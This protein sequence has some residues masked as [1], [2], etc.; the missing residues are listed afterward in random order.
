MGSK[1][2]FAIRA[3]IPHENGGFVV[4]TFLITGPESPDEIELIDFYLAL[5]DS[6]ISVFEGVGDGP[7]DTGQDSMKS[8]ASGLP[9]P[10][11]DKIVMQ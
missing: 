1:K 9:K 5:G 10:P 4:D 7:I 8:P 3:T 11:R 6:A 2:L